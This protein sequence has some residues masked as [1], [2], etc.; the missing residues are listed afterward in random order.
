VEQTLG[1]LETEENPLSFRLRTPYKMVQTL[2]QNK[3]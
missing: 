2:K 3:N 1:Q